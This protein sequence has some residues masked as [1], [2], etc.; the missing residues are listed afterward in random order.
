[1]HSI[2]TNQ[3][4]Q[5]KVFIAACYTLSLNEN[6]LLIAAIS[7]IDPISHAWKTGKCDITVTVDEWSQLFTIHSHCNYA[8]LRQAAFKLYERS[9]K[10]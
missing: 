8:Q 7:K 9:S 10:L 2:E 1:M 5:D 4:A 6:R 3:V